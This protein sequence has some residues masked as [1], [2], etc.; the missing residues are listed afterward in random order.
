VSRATYRYVTFHGIGDPPRA[1]DPGEDR[2]WVSRRQFVAT[3]DAVADRPDVR[4][5]FDDGNA[6]DIVHALPE[7]R[8]RGL[9]AT[10]FVVAGRL[11]APGFLSRDDV[12]TLTAAGM[13]V[14]CHGM[15]HR[16]WRRLD[17]RALSVELL[18]ARR[19]L[20]DIVQRP[21]REAACPFGAYDRRVLRSLRRYGYEQVYTSDRGAAPAGAF[22]QPRNSVG[23][24]DGAR[25]LEDITGTGRRRA[26]AAMRRR[27]KLAAK[28]WR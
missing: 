15:R 13:T 19:L 25:V 17:D 11:G 1:L 28:H 18:D 4:I 23:P 9:H 7:L 2:V 8:R 6:S 22:V 5:T 3:L 27:A 21:V 24:S 14:G 26:A 16:A 12:A 20:E 10:F